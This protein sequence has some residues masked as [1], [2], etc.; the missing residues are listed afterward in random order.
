MVPMDSTRPP[1][2]K[3]PPLDLMLLHL[4][5]VLHLPLSSMIVPLVWELGNNLLFCCTALQTSNCARCDALSFGNILK[6][7]DLIV[8]MQPCTPSPLAPWAEEVA[9]VSA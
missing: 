1:S 6:N 7:T 2:T 5:H 9:T 4:Q 8:R 3:L